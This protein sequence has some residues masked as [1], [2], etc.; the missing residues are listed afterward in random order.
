M[1][2]STSCT[3]DND[4]NTSRESETVIEMRNVATPAPNSNNSS[5]VN[6][7]TS[8]LGHLDPHRLRD[9]VVDKQTACQ[10]QVESP[11]KQPYWTPSPADHSQS[12]S[13]N[14]RSVSASSSSPVTPV[15]HPPRLPS[16]IR[17]S[18]LLSPSAARNPVQQPIGMCLSVRSPMGSPSSMH[19]PLSPFISRPSS[20]APSPYMQPP[21]TPIHYQTNLQSPAGVIPS[22]HVPPSP[23]C[24]PYLS[25]MPAVGPSQQ[26]YPCHAQMQQPQW[27]NQQAQQHF[28]SGSVHRVMVQRVPYSGYPPTMS[29]LQPQ[30]S[31]HPS[32]SNVFPAGATGASVTPASRGAIYPSPSAVPCQQSSGPQST[33]YPP[34]SCYQPKGQRQPKY[35]VQSPVYRQQQPQ[36]VSVRT[37]L[38]NQQSSL[39]ASPTYQRELFK[40]APQLLLLWFS[41]VIQAKF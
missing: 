36:T 4:A 19:P 38:G 18:A 12:P 22:N 17:D 6:E 25:R 35:P 27:T 16:A 24:T 8:P 23:P 11:Y 29:Q 32:S 1:E 13:S 34:Q 14:I 41:P 7:A 26:Q 3:S 20:N 40:A 39:S 33:P 21:Q 30:N 37:Y 15:M 28:G 9:M 10:T 31:Q 5:F 2:G